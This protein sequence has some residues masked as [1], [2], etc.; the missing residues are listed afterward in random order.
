MGGAIHLLH[1]CPWEGATIF[2]FV[3]KEGRHGPPKEL[4]LP[5]VLKAP[6]AGRFLSTKDRQS[7]ILLSCKGCLYFITRVISDYSSAC[8]VKTFPGC[9]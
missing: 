6:P 8:Q 4:S 3:I 5:D 7:H 2:G 1:L 9:S